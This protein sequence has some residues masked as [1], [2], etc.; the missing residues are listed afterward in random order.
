MKFVQ[1]QV[2]VILSIYETYIREII[3]SV[4]NYKNYPTYQTTTD[5]SINQHEKRQNTTNAS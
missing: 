3:L 5:K 4:R 1:M 2:C